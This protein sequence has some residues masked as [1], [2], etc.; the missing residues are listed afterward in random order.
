VAGQGQP[1]RQPLVEQLPAVHVQSRGDDK[2][3]FVNQARLE[4]RVSQR[5]AP[6]HPD[7]AAGPLLEPGHELAYVSV[8][9][10]RVGP[11]FAGRR[12]GRDEFLDAVYE[13][14]ERF[15]V[16][17][18]PEGGPVVIGS[19]PEEHGVLGSD[20]T[21]QILPHQIVELGYELVGLLSHTIE[22][23]QLVDDYLAHRDLLPF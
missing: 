5:D 10:R 17:G 22:R 16:A 1:P 21:A 8:N 11:A 12:R 9:D 14:G 18:G 6:V 4:Q 3:Q 20:D 19:A 13:G 23:Q 2:P 7:I 15:D